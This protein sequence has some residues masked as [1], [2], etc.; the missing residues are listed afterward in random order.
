MLSYINPIKLQNMLTAYP[1]GAPICNWLYCLCLT[2]CSV[3]EA[4][5][6]TAFIY[7]AS[8]N[9]IS[10]GMPFIYFGRLLATGKVFDL[11][12]QL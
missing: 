7:E 10:T 5:R 3:V 4:Y 2:V 6:R 11:V 9:I 8:Y 12:G 1:C